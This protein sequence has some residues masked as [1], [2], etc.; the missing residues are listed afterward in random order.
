MNAL[1]IIKVTNLDSF[2][3]HLT[4]IRECIYLRKCQGLK[5]WVNP[6]RVFPSVILVYY[7]TL[8][9]TYIV[10]CIPLFSIQGLGLLTTRVINPLFNNY[11]VI[12]SMI[13]RLL[14]WTVKSKKKNAFIF[15]NS[16]FI[17]DKFVLG[18]DWHK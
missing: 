5:K 10:P 16:Y 6:T 2:L 1:L 8:R 4:N 14:K 13:S 17:N 11:Y 9:V 3:V 15:L 12:S 18:I 7:R